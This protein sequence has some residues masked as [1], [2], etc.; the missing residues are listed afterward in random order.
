LYNINMTIK[1]KKSKQ[2]KAIISETLSPY[3]PIAHVKKQKT[4]YQYRDE[5]NPYSVALT[6]QDK[7]IL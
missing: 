3:D 1:K 7:N 5:K 2:D 4:T 6:L